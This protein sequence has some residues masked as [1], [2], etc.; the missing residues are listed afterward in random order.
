MLI[1]FLP[2]IAFVI[3][4]EQ[5][6]FSGL[7]IGD[8]KTTMICVVVAFIVSFV[9]FLRLLWR[10]RKNRQHATVSQPKAAAPDYSDN[11]SFRVA[12]VTFDNDDGTSRQRLL[13]SL[14][15]GEHPF[16]GAHD[17]FF[18]TIE[19]TTFEGETALAV[20][21]DDFQIGFVPKSL[22]PRVQKAMANVATFQVVDYEV[23]GGGVG[24]DGTPLSYGC[25]IT[26]D[27]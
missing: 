12:G 27:C 16:A 2:L 17:D 6:V 25:T 20:M 18:P 7:R 19:E 26:I 8:F 14:K 23:V 22:I 4:V 5:V 21:I 11:F 3:F 9:L 24:A 10:P 1:A 13:R 15:F